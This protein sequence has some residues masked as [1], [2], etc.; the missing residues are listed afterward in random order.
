MNKIKKYIVAIVVML[1]VSITMLF[2][3][4]TFAYVFKWQSDKAMI[5]IILTYILAGLAGGECL[6][7]FGKKEIVKKAVEALILS[8]LFMLLLLVISVFGL[9]ISFVFSGR[10]FL[11]WLLLFGTTFL[12]RVL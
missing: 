12:G 11:I 8:T 10:F 7:R 1:V 2:L 3:V 9:Q 6:K 5:G 4:T